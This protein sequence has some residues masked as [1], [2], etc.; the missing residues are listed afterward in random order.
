MSRGMTID[1]VAVVIGFFIFVS[2]G[3]SVGVALAASATVV[4]LVDVGW[5]LFHSR[6]NR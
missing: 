4:A 2:V 6:R 3:A 1:A 5:W